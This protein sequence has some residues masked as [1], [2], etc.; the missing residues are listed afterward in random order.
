MIEA[1]WLLV[2]AAL[3]ACATWGVRRRCDLEIERMRREAYELML[4]L[5]HTR[6]CARGMV[7]DKAECSCGL[8]E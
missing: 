5:G 2:A 7:W 6:E 1:T 3:I 8:E 4:W